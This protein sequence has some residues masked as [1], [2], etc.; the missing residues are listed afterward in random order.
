MAPLHLALRDA[1]STD[2]E[3]QEVWREISQR[4]ASNMR[5]LIQDLK[6]TGRLRRGLSIDDAADMLWATNSAELYVMLT[7]ERRWSAKRYERWL[8]DSW[9]RLLLE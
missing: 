6:S 3:S 7:G 5:R 9:C 2:R 8:A 1:S 4:R